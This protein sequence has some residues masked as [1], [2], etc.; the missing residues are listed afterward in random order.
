MRTYKGRLSP[1]YDS[2]GEFSHVLEIVRDISEMK[3]MAQELSVSETHLR[4][5]LQAVRMGTWEWDN[6][7]E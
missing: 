2:Q 7:D 5:A 4:L 1:L 6:Q 3:E